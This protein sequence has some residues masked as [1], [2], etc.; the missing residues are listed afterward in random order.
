MLIFC[1]AL[2][3]LGPTASLPSGVM[4][5]GST[6]RPGPRKNL[7]FSLYGALSPVGFF[8]GIF[9]GAISVE[10]LSWS[11]YFWVGAIALFAVAPMALLVA[12]S[13][14]VRIDDV[15]MDW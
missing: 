2:Q 9:C 12:P 6:Y 3:D 10:Y 8:A 11:W 5:L 4:L 15:E 13:E 1:R 14:P 7:V